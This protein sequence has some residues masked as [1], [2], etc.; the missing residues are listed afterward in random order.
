MRGTALSPLGP[1]I[2]FALRLCEL[3][4]QVVGREKLPRRKIV[5]LGGRVGFPDSACSVSSFVVVTS[6]YYSEEEAVFVGPSAPNLPT[7]LPTSLPSIRSS[8]RECLAPVCRPQD[9]AYPIAP[10]LSDA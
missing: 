7:Y 6:L 9:I 2:V 10:T 3:W 8:A 5:V 1:V 4:R